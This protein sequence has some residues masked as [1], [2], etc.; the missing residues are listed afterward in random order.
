ML[1][2]PTAFPVIPWHEQ[3]ASCLCVDCRSFDRQFG[4]AVYRHP[5]RQL[6]NVMGKEEAVHGRG[7]S[8]DHCLS[9]RAG[10]GKR[11]R[12]WDLVDIR[13][14]SCFDG[15]QGLHHYHGYGFHVLSRLCYQYGYVFGC[16]S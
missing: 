9:A 4:S 11:D 2:Q 12:G 15:R 6:S 1:T 10:M 3:V 8:S 7:C 16:L 5:E 14:R 13:G